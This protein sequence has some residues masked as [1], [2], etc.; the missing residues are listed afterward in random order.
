M[1]RSIRSSGSISSTLAVALVA[2]L[3]Q[4]GASA[5][6]VEPDVNVIATLTDPD[7]MAG[8]FG[9]AV[10]EIGDIDGDG[11]MDALVGAPFTGADG[12]TGRAYAFSGRTGALIWLWEGQPADGLGYSMADAGDVD[13]DGVSDAIFGSIASGGTGKATI[14]SGATGLVIRELFGEAPGDQFGASVAGVGDINNDG[15]SD[16]LVGANAHDTGALNAGRAYVYSGADGSLIRTHDGALQGGLLGSGA[17]DVQ[18]INNDGV[19]DYI[20]GA[21][22]GPPTDQGRCFVFSGADGAQ[23]LPE[24]LPNPA[25]GL[26]LAWFFVDGIGD[27]TG[28]GVPDLYAGDFSDSAGSG[29]AY[30]YDGL[31]GSIALEIASDEAGAGLGC[32]RGAGDVDGDGRDDLA[33]GLYTSSAGA[34]QAGRI[35]VYSGADGSILRELTG[36]NPG[37]QLGFDVVGIGDVNADCGLDLLCSAANGETVYIVAGDPGQ[38]P[39]DANADF[40]VNFLDILAVLTNWGADYGS[41]TGPGDANF[42]GAVNFFDFRAV[43]SNFKSSCD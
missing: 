20:V 11:A 43:L 4:S 6:F 27:A 28:D 8:A 3:C 14:F 32:G 39:G 24:L 16:V 36:T 10:S 22:G 37:F 23:L 12:I 31:D 13:G 42:D 2:G 33:I 29:R 41:G 21:R 7:G 30:I 38:L 25:T 5:Q 40:T 26:D 15:F 9:W 35:R 1:N 18:D 19:P 34:V 17:G